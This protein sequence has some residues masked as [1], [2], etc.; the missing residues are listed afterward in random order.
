MYNWGLLAY[1]G[2]VGKV[3]SALSFFYRGPSSREYTPLFLG[4]GFAAFLGWGF[5]LQR[6]GMGFC[7][8]LLVN[9][10]KALNLI[11]TVITGYSE[12]ISLWKPA[13]VG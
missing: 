9:F 10:I 12:V 6:F 8:V 1:E 2:V 13:I 4:W 7:S 5:F 11:P 3:G